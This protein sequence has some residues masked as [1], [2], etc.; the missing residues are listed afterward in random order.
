MKPE[1]YKYS[2]EKRLKYDGKCWE[3]FFCILTSWGGV[4]LY[5]SEYYD[6]DKKLEY[7]SGLESHYRVPPEYM[8][9]MAPSHNECWLIKCPCW[10]DGTSLYAQEHFLPIFLQSDH[11][12]VFDALTIYCDDNKTEEL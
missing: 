10:H 5:I 9:D 7:F 3:H 12:A 1:K 8:K 4:H 2:Y 11:K 6:S